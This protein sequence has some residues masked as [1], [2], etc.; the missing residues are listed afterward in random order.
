ME[1]RLFTL[2]EH[3]KSLSR[4]AIDTSTGML[5]TTESVGSSSS[6]NNGG[7]DSNKLTLNDLKSFFT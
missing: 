4:S 2:Q 6:S 7:D 5:H 3:K 1:E